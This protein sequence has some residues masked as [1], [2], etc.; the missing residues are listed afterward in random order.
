MYRFAVSVL[1]AS[2]LV[3]SMM[4]VGAAGVSSAA[5][6]ARELVESKYN[7]QAT[8]ERL[9][10]AIRANKIGLVNRANAQAGANSIGVKIRGNQVWGL[11]APRFA[12]R[13]L[14]A[15]IEAGI[16]AP[17]RLYITENDAGLVTVSY[18][19]PTVVF[20]PYEIADLNAMAVELDGLFERV[21]ETVAR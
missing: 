3:Y 18:V 2:I 15:S 6:P 7:F 10:T 5:P 4:A 19:K 14:E 8:L 16:E 17:L 12:V 20:A 1:L 21:T 11:F 9:R 13:M